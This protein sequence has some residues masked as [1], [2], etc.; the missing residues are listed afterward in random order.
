MNDFQIGITIE[1]IDNFSKTGNLLKANI[2]SIS[3]SLDNLSKESVKTGS[4]LENLEKRFN[5]L[6]SIITGIISSQAFI[7]PIQQASSYIENLNKLSVSFEDYGKAIQK[8][9]E[10]SNQLGLSKNKVIEY[11]STYKNILSGLGL[12]EE[13]A[14]ALSEAF[15]RLTADISSYYNI[16]FD[17]ASSKLQSAI[18]GEFQALKSLGIVINENIVKQKMMELGLKDY[19]NTTE[20]TIAI[21]EILK[22]KFKA[23][24][25]DIERT[26]DSFSNTIRRISETIQ[27][28]L[29]TIGL[30]IIETIKPIIQGVDI[31]LQYIDRFL[32]EVLPKSKFLQT[33]I[34]GLLLLGTTFLTLGFNIRRALVVS[35][36]GT[37]LLLVLNIVMYVIENLENVKKRVNEIGMNISGF[38]TGL[39]DT[40]VSVV[41]L[42][43]TIFENLKNVIQAI[44]H[45]IIN[46]VKVWFTD[47]LNFL[48]D[49]VNQISKIFGLKEIG[50]IEVK[51]NFVDLKK[52]FD[53]GTRKYKDASQ[54]ISENFKKTLENGGKALENAGKLIGGFIFDNTKQTIE[55]IRQSQFGLM[56]EK[57]K[58]GG[59][60]QK[61]QQI[62]YGQIQNILQSISFIFQKEFLDKILPKIDE[63]LQTMNNNLDKMIGSLLGIP[64]GVFDWVSILIQLLMTFFNKLVELTPAL[65]SLLNIFNFFVEVV[66]TG[67]AP[68]LNQTLLQIVNAIQEVIE[69]LAVIFVDVLTPILEAIKISFDALAPFLFLLAEI[70]RQIAPIITQ[71]V[72]IVIEIS[73]FV[74]PIL[75]VLK[76][77]LDAMIFLLNK[78]VIPIVNFLI[79][80]I[81]GIISI[82]EGAF[83]GIIRFI[84]GIIETINNVLGWTGLKLGKIGELNFGRFQELQEIKPENIQIPNQNININQNINTGGSIGS[85]SGASG[86]S[87]RQVAPIYIYMTNNG[88]IATGMKTED[89][90]LKWIKQG[91]ENLERRGY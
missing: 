11:F 55:E 25:G 6:N 91:I 41:N 30:A 85:T 21:T 12:T 17:E 49:I 59:G 33:L 82:I 2:E 40:I 88:V 66:A 50:K 64:T 72:K 47:F 23:V 70:L 78:V 69:A 13:K 5:F 80:I 76:V 84:N 75:N 22:E 38:F 16:S 9:N 4:F 42:I 43:I 58:S 46:Q 68:I 24:S 44:F 52:V 20:R 7:K 15:T 74:N 35:G 29:S 63:V 45:N 36:I 65:Q 3:K 90:F 34:M 26:K 79:K 89:D 67:I 8:V 83:N 56:V 62:V 86:L 60:E 37:F 28:I 54:K 71:L 53:E 81:N 61:E 32:S 73:K 39:K 57:E 31:V 87:V 14:N 77:V 18:T 19:N 10:L 1:A 51:G 27:N 48:I